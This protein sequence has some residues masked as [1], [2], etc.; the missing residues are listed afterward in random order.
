MRPRKIHFF[1]PEPERGMPVE[2]SRNHYSRGERG[3]LCGYMRLVTFNKSE[4]T[5]YYCLRKLGT[6]RL[7][8]IGGTSRA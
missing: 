3:T 4:V 2:I 8:A 1:C 6:H 7:S 5:C